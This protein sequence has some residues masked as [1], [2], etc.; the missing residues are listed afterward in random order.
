[1]KRLLWKR[2][3]RSI[4]VILGVSMLAFLF[5]HLSGDPAA[6]M[7]PLDASPEQVATLRHSLGLDDPLWLQY[8][9]FMQQ[10]VTGDFGMS[11]RHKQPALGLILE[12]LPATLEL[13]VASLAISLLIAVPLGVWTATNRRSLGDHAGTLLGVFGQS[14]PVFWIALMLQLVFGLLVPILPISGRGSLTQL[15]LPALSLGMYSTATIMRLLKSNMVEVL[16]QDYVRTARAKG[17]SQK[18]VTIKHALRNALLPVVTVVGMQIGVLLGGAVITE[19]I[20]AWPGVGRLMVQAINNRDIP[21][22]QAGV[23][24]L[25]IGI[26][27][28]NLATDLIYTWLDPRIRLDG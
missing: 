13:S 27:L 23:F 4:L 15:I 22:V 17:L 14:M 7:L 2:L 21:L 9:R 6:L 26:V 12:R 11:I 1:M 18:L 8:L 25:A 24:V 16:Q 19:S 28:I 5:V 20:F 3:K 10:A